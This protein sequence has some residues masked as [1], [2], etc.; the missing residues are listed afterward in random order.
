MLL[1]ILKACTKFI[2]L[3]KA[4]DIAS[5]RFDSISVAINQSKHF[6]IKDIIYFYLRF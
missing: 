5:L 4:D 3:N 6:K 2:K 1:W